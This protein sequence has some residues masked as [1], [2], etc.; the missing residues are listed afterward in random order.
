MSVINAE[1]GLL[2]PLKG[3]EIKL[4]LME[5]KAPA[6]AVM[7]QL[8]SSHVPLIEE[9]SRYILFSDGKRLRPVL[10]LLCA[11]ILGRPAPAE[12]SVIFEYLH[13][14]SLLHD[15]VIDN[16]GLRRG[17]VAAQIKY[18][19]PEVILVGDF[20]FAKSYFL[21]ATHPDPAFSSALAQC[22]AAMAE[23][24][25]LELMHTGNLEL[26]EAAYE[27]IIIGKTAIL[28]ATACKMAAIYA[29]A[30]PAVIEALYQYGVHLGIAFQMVD[31]ALDYS[32]SEKEVGKEV[33]HDLQE[34][35][36]TLP[37][38]WTRDNSQQ[39]D[40]LMELARW[41][42]NNPANSHQA[43][44][45]VRA[46]GGV[47]ATMEQALGQA[48]TAQNILKTLDLP[49]GQDLDLLYSLASYVVTRRN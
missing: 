39:R 6:D 7:G 4:R 8:L 41:A 28:I 48:Q 44:E 12:L 23:G 42:R 37:F 26:D 10:F 13:A 25:I 31:D 46:H 29:K 15:D 11:R 21:S 32:A 45:I 24:Q 20:L 33:D 27:Q 18:G 1:N 30:P 34:G 5:L 22:S 14:A 36:I 47:T 17:Q 40:K 3:E 49:P 9:V 35:K 16:A 19:N 2:A 38:I 43:G